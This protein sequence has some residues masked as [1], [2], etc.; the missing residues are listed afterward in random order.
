[1]K[2]ELPLSP[3]QFKSNSKCVKEL[4]V[5]P[6]TVL[7][8]E[9]SA[10]RPRQDRNIGKKFSKKFSIAKETSADED[11]GWRLGKKYLPA[12]HHTEDSY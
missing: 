12:V 6:K 10:G 8:A 7:Y 4:D 2:L 11:I 3:A 1:M 9:E 5:R